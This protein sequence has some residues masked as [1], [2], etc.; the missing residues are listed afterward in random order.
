MIIGLLIVIGLVIFVGAGR[1]S[2]HPAFGHLLPFRFAQRAKA[3]KFKAFARL[4]LQM[5]EGARRADE[6]SY[7]RFKSMLSHT[8]FKL[9]NISWLQTRSTCQPCVSKNVVRFLSFAISAAVLW[10]TPSTA[11]INFCWRQ[12]KSAKYGPMLNWRTNLWLPRLRSRL[13]EAPGNGFWRGLKDWQW[14]YIYRILSVVKSPHPAF[15]HL[16]PSEG[17]REKAILLALPTLGWRIPFRSAL[18]IGRFDPPMEKCGRLVAY[19]TPHRV[20]A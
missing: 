1:K 2:P 13:C 5:G 19:A 3:M 6:G 12:A 7:S 15:G 8:P 11:I 10:V 14:G 18:S 17:G 16:L 9:V 4:P 20:P